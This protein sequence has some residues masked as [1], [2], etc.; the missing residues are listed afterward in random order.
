MENLDTNNTQYE[1]AINEY[2]DTNKDNQFKLETTAIAASR[3][4]AI[5][6]KE[7]SLQN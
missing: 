4:L 3:A 5:P 1:G 6:Q 7:E 2:L